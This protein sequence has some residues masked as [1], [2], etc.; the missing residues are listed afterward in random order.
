MFFDLK[1]EEEAEWVNTLPLL[2]LV[3]AARTNHELPPGIRRLLY[4]K[5]NHFL[6]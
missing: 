3:I 1:R 2:P 5:V 6:L 4:C